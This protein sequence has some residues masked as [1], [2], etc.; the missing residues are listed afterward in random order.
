MRPIAIGYYWRRLTA[1]FANTIALD[2]LGD[3]FAP[4]QLGVGVKDGCEAAIQAARRFCSTMS[5]EQILVKLDFRNAFNSIHRETVLRAVAA[6][7]P[8][9]YAFCY[10]TYANH[11]SLLFGKDLISSEDGVQ[12]GDPLGP[13]LF[14]L[15]IHIILTAF[16]S[17]FIAC[18]MDDVTLGGDADTIERDVLQMVETGSRIGLVLNPTKSELIAQVSGNHIPLS[19]ES[20]MSGFSVLDMDNAQLLGSPIL[21]GLAMNSILSA[22][23]DDLERAM[24]RLCFLEAQDALLILRSAYSSPKLL[25]VLRSSPCCGHPSLAHFDAHLRTGLSSII[26]C[27]MSNLAWIQASQPIRCGGL[28]VRS[29]EMLAPSAF[30]ASAAA[31]LDLQS[32]ILARCQPVSDPFIAPTLEIWE[33]LFKGT[34]PTGPSATKQS[35]WDKA[36]IQK[37]QQILQEG[38]TTQVDKARLLAVSE[39]GNGDWLKAYPISSCGLRLDNEVLRIAVGLRLGLPLCEEHPCPCGETVDRSGLHGLSCHTAEGKM[40]IDTR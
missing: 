34:V 14:C 31:T 25:N 1:K 36:S 5:T 29:V 17:P 3:F 28:G 15:S 20:P 6:H 37:S 32:D 18:F 30:L 2:Q 26:N 11:T 39:P 40:A 24:T 10:L 9:I 12:Q 13:L 33:A 27:D 22:R 7:I 23:V 38:V 19:T 4:I 21:T 8:V 16:Q 35:S